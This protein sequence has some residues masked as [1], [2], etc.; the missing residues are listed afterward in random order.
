MNTQR[1]E[2]LKASMW[3]AFLA[4]RDVS[5]PNLGV[6]TNL[7]LL[8]SHGYFSAIE[9]LSTLEEGWTKNAQGE[10]IHPQQWTPQGVRSI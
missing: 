8:S 7:D 5:A 6:S 3:D 1:I 9:E 10:W 2:Q 4:S